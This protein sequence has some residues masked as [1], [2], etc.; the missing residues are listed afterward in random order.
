ML[1]LRLRRVIDESSRR[2]DKAEAI[3]KFEQ[4][5]YLHLFV[6]ALRIFP[7]TLLTQLC[8]MERHARVSMRDHR[9]ARAATRAR[10]R[11]GRAAGP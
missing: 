10:L 4:F 6:K 8:V 5:S 11:Q 3:L 7:E 9:H 2:Q 1:M